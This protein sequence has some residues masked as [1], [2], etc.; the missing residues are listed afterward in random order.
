MQKFQA[1]LAYEGTA[2]LG[3]QKTSLGLTIQE[4]LSKSIAKLSPTSPLPEAA[5]RTDRGV[6]AEGQSVSFEAHTKLDPPTL[7]KALNAH[8]PKDIRIRSLSLVPTHFHPTLDAK[9]KEYRYRVSFADIQDPMERH[10]FWSFPYTLDLKEMERAAKLLLGTKDYSALA[11]TMSNG[12]IENPICTL[13]RIDLHLLPNSRLEIAIL[14]N[15]F[16]YKMARN[17]GGLLLFVGRGKLRAER[18]PHLLDAKKRSLSAM[19]APAHGLTLYRVD[20]S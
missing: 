5:S 12:K 7:Q 11:N 13:E 20:Y 8:L 4:A 9:R 18:I 14:G 3:W 17:I 1:I 15:R 6:H 10:F 19:T 16:L 2:Y